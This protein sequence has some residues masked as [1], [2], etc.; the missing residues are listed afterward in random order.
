MNKRKKV[1]T[2]AIDGTDVEYLCLHYLAVLLFEGEG[3]SFTNPLKKVWLQHLQLLSMAYQIIA[4][5][6]SS[7]REMLSM[8]LIIS[9]KW[10]CVP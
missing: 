2:V 1:I 5:L 4:L 6:H 8:A 7:K 3:C 9:I 10:F